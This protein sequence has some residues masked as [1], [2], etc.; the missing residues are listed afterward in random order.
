MFEQSCTV[1]NGVTQSIAK[2]K[3]TYLHLAVSSK[4][5]LH[6]QLNE[7]RVELEDCVARS[8][9]SIHYEIALPCISCVVG[10][11]EPIHFIYILHLDRSVCSAYWIEVPGMSELS[12]IRFPGVLA[13]F[14]NKNSNQ[15]RKLSTW[16]LDR[17]LEQKRPWD[18]G[19]RASISHLMRS[20]EL[21]Q[22]E[23]KERNP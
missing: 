22:N 23:C 6:H 1:V 19:P 14:Y 3:P 21:F 4:Q 5:H 12:A 13:W 18:Y 7:N 16:P 8:L 20:N 17:F 9:L 10:Q 15:S 2:R 11:A